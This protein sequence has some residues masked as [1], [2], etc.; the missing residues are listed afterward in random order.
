MAVLVGFGVGGNGQVVAAIMMITLPTGV[1][2]IVV[3]ILIVGA[4][5]VRERI[6]SFC[7]PP[8]RRPGHSIMPSINILR[9]PK[10]LFPQLRARPY[11]RSLR[12]RQFP[13]IQADP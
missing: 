8:R 6:R 13:I 5:R 10:L 4:F 3:V 2:D 7:P 9:G 11:E 12:G 1:F